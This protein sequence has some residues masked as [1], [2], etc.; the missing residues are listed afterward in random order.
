LSKKEEM[1]LF[2]KKGLIAFNEKNFYDAHE[3]WEDLWTNFYFKDRLLI[4]GLIQVS[5][6]YFHITNLNLRGARGLFKK[7]LPKLQK[8][9]ISNQRL[10]NLCELITTIKSAKACVEEIENINDFNW[11]LTIILKAK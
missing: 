1:D 2:F 10:E 4:Q 5:V 7:C 8:F 9:K 11:D 6:G 3:Y